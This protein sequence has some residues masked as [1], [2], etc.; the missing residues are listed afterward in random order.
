MIRIDIYREIDFDVQLL[1]IYGYYK[2]FY[3]IPI[4]SLTKKHF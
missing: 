1:V 4:L 3:K 2:L